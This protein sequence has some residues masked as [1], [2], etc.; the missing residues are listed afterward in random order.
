MNV[1]SLLACS[2]GACA[3]TRRCAESAASCCGVC[4]ADAELA[5]GATTPTATVTPAA[6]APVDS[7]DRNRFTVGPLVFGCREETRA[8]RRV[9][10][11]GFWS[12]P[13]RDRPLESDRPGVEGAG[14][15]WPVVGD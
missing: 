9:R 14:V 15:A 12:R 7:R 13:D 4:A 10:P 6:T 5:V 2:A 1:S 3:A 11:A 8:R